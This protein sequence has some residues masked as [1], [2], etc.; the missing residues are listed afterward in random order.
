[1]TLDPWSLG[2]GSRFVMDAV[3]QITT[4]APT[5][6]RRMTESLIAPAVLSK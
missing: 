3:P 2:G 1:M 5:L 4:R 6:R